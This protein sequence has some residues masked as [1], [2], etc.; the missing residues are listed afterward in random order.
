MKKKSKSFLVLKGSRKT[1]YLIKRIRK[2]FP[3]SKIILV[4]KSKNCFAKKYSDEFI[5]TDSEN[6]RKIRKYINFKN[7]FMCI[8]RSSGPSTIIAI[9]INSIIGFQSS[10]YQ[11]IKNTISKMQL[12]QFCKKNKMEYIKTNLIKKS[13]KLNYPIIIKSD[14]EKRG[15]INVFLIKNKKNFSKN[16]KISRILSFNKKV[17]SQEYIEGFDI[18]V[19]GYTDDKNKFIF[20]RFYK[21]MNRFSENGSII[22]EGFNLINFF[23]KKKYFKLIKNDINKVINKF[24]L[25]LAPFNFN[26]RIMKSQKKIYL[27]ELNLFFG[28]ENLM[29]NDYDLITPYLKL[30]KRLS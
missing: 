12:S 28:G 23:K 29:E 20:K 1:V 16:Y 17:I 13:S 18:T 3:N 19:C 7:L 21:E 10:N 6:F 2:I 11:L 27:N 22:H 26:F 4:D 9:K 25:K 5:N 14:I 8:T 15:K 24:Q 30:I